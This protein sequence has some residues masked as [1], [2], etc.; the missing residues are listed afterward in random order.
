MG[1]IKFISLTYINGTKTYV[2]ADAIVQMFEQ[3]G[4]TYVY[5]IGSNAPI[6]AKESMEEILY[7]LSNL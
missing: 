1:E 6:V 7:D 2:K 3:D 4:N 5:I